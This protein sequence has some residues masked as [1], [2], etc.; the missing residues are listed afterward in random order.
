MRGCGRASA[1][2]EGQR[3]TVGAPRRADAHLGHF[4]R[5]RGRCASAVFTSGDASRQQLFGRATPHPPASLP[6][7]GLYRIARQAVAL[8][9]VQHPEL[10]DDALAPT[11]AR[12][13]DPFDAVLE[14]RKAVVDDRRLLAASTSSRPRLAADLRRD[15]AVGQGCYWR[16]WR[17]GSPANSGHWMPRR[18]SLRSRHS[19]GGLNARKKAGPSPAFLE[20]SASLQMAR[21]S[22]RAAARA[23]LRTLARS[24]L[25]STRVTPWP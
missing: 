13:F 16:V 15:R 6:A 17:T 1:S 24:T 21:R 18:N 9:G 14:C 3:F 25:D 20:R 8:G 11:V 23:W 19:H 10:A 2:R 22:P 12:S 7:A 4:A 5:H